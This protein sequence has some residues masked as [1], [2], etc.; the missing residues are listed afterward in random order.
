MLR[1]EDEDDDE[2]LGK[3]IWNLEIKLLQNEN[4][5]DH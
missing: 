3:W 2:H 4:V 5:V 1:D